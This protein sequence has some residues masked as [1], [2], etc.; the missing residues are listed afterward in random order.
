MEVGRIEPI[1]GQYK[2]M[3]KSSQ[4]SGS[5][6]QSGEGEQNKV[7]TPIT[8]KEVKQVVEDLNRMFEPSQT[9]IKFN[10]HE[11]LGEYY[12]QVVND[13]N[14]E[15]IREIPSKKILDIMASFRESIG[16]VIDQKI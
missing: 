15:V 12:V 3:N 1:S 14:N 9:H 16:L 4:Y 8:E 11:K 6:N 10:F 5:P 2:P 7:F 13:L